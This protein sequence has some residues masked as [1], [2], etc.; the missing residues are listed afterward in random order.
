MPQKP[1]MTY[2]EALKHNERERLRRQGHPVP[3]KSASSST[4]DKRYS[5]H[6]PEKKVKGKKITERVDAYF[7]HY[8][9]RSLDSDNH[10]GKHCTD[11]IVE[12]GILHDDSR[13]YIRRTIHEEIII[14]SWDMP[15]TDIKLISIGELL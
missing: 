10:F 8:R 4:I 1:I 15:Y 2:E 11:A 6:E 5:I 14:P 7:Y 13:K 3:S 12:A 9:H